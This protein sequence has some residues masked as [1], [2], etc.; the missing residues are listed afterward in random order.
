MGENFIF[1][2]R[3]DLFILK[4]IEEIKLKQATA[5]TLI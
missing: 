1:V 4:T 3:K 2:L 5:L